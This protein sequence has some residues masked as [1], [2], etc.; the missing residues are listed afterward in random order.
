MR[1]PCVFS[2]RTRR[3]GTLDILFKREQTSGRVGRVKFKLWGKVELDND[4]QVIAHRYNFD[5]AILIVAD[6][7]NLLR[8]C[9]LI[10]VVVF[11]VSLGVLGSFLEDRLM[12]LG[13]SVLVAG[14]AG[15]WYFNEKRETI[16]V[17]DLIHGR[18]FSCDSVI[19][20]AQKEAWLTAVTSFLRQVMESAKQWN[21][22]ER[23][24]VEPL[25]KDEARQIIIKGL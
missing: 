3:D 12:A 14:G 20:L 7:P 4:E 13:A 18:H 24:T 19:E 1:D 16:F 15:Y 25:P 8:C 2:V 23:H 5:N 21:G 17:K 6:Q 9:L 11:V 22:T 10:A